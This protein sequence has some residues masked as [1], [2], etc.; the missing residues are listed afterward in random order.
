MYMLY[1]CILILKRLNSA[2]NKRRIHMKFNEYT[3]KRPDINAFK[4]EWQGLLKQF[5]ATDSLRKQNDLIYS[6]NVMRDEFESMHCLVVIRHTIN[7]LD[8]FYDQEMNYFDLNLPLYEDLVNEYYKA[9][10]GSS[11]IDQLKQNWGEQLFAIAEAEIKTFSQ[12][13]I[14]ELQ[15]E[16]QLASAYE[17]LLASAAIE[18]DGKVL[19]LAQLRPYMESSNRDVRKSAWEAWSSFFAQHEDEFDSLFDKLVKVRHQIAKKLGYE[20]FTPVGYLRLQRLDYAAKDVEAFRDEVAEYVV[21]V[22]E[23]LSRRQQTRLALQNLY[24]YDESLEFNSGNATPKGDA[25]WML[26]QAKQM[27][28]EL[29]T[30]TEEFFTYMKERELFD[31]LS[32]AGTAS[33]G[34]CTYIGKFKAPFIFANFNGT[35][36]DVGVLTHEMGHAFQAYRCRNFQIPEYQNPTLETCEIH[37]NAMEYLTWPWMGLLFEED[38]D[39]YKYS[40]LASALQFIPYGAAVDE[41]QHFVYA[42]PNISPTARKNKW[43]ELEQK[44]LPYRDYENNEILAKGGFWFK[45]LHIFLDPFY[46]IDYALAY[47]CALQLWVS[48]QENFANTWVSYLKLC[49]MGGSK[50]FLDLLKASGLKSPFAAGTV[51][52]VIQPIV[53]WLDSVDDK[54]W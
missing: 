11:C 13:I 24:Y 34:Y 21:P 41:F 17:K 1:L 30:E 44:Y 47:I 36:G 51:A 5:L 49:D 28:S 46:Y 40:H 45:Q 9:L 37:A 33:G 10:L 48:S 6:F 31:V 35:A 52:S 8:E 12:E 2:Q 3:Y 54:Q 39:K 14:P 7:T 50:S 23:S 32:K 4:V 43:R 20:N 42:N 18:Y 16:N 19:N 29:A 15:I 38:E 27:Y 53:A 25:D 22:A 26:A